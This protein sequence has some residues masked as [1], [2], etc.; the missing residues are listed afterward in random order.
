[1]ITHFFNP[2]RYMQLLELVRGT[3]TT[4]DVY[5]TMIE[6]GESILGKG[7]VHAKDTPNFIGNRI[8]VYG[9]MIAINLAKEHGLSVEEVDK[10]TGPISGRPK[11]ATF[12]TADIVGLDTLKNVSLTTYEKASDDEERDKFQI[13]SILEN[14]IEAGRLGQKTK[15][16]FYK[17]NEDRSIHS[18]DLKTG[19][20][21]PMIQYGLIASELQKIDKD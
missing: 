14:L 10:L 18:V 11:S 5:K 19:E 6:F 13:P 8:G 21:G 9:M 3:Q 1:M 17:K 12:R 16:G 20:Y 15:S 7:I 2:P 4:D